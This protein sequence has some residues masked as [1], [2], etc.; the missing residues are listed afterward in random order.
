[1]TAEGVSAKRFK[2]RFGSDLEVIFAD[3][4]RHLL[5]E[6]LIEWITVPE[7]AVRLT[8][9]GNLLGNRVFMEFVGYEVA[10]GLL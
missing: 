1:M 5:G 4:L 3:Q 8:K 7:R 9:R 10:A 2:N 6:G